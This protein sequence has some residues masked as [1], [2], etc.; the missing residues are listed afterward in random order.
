[1][2]KFYQTLKQLSLLLLLLFVSGIAFGQTTY[3]DDNFDDGDILGWTEGSTGDWVSSTDTPINGT[4]S[5]KHNLSG[6]SGTSYISTTISSADLTVEDFTWRFQLQNG[7]WDPSSSNKFWVYIVANESDLTSSTVDGYAVGVNLTGSSDLLTL[8]KVTDGAADVALITSTFDW[9]SSNVVGIEVT[10]SSLGGWELSFDSDGGFDALS[11]AGTASNSDYTTFTDFGLEFTFSSTRAGLLWMDDVNV[12]GTAAATNTIVQFSSASASIGE[13]DGTYNITLSIA[14][15]DA[16][17]ATTV[18]VA[19][20]SGDAA[21]I[22]SYTTQ[23][24]TFAAGSSADETV[25]LTITDDATYEGDETLTFTLQNVSGGNSAALGAQTTFDL[26]IMDNDPLPEATLPYSETFDTDLSGVYTYSVSGATKEWYYSSGV[27]VANGYNS[28]DVEEDWLILPSI[29]LDNYTSE[30]INFDTEYSFG[31]DDANNYLKLMYSTDY[32][33]TGDPTSA[34]WTELSYTQPA[35]SGTQTNS[36]NVDL[37]SI[38]GTSVYLAFKYRYES[39]SYRSWEVDNIIVEETPASILTVTA[40]LTDFGNVDVNTTSA[41]QTFTVEG[42]ALTGDITVTTPTNFEVSLTS[43]SGFGSSVS[44]TPSSGTVATTSIFVRF[45]PTSTLN[46]LKSGE[47]TVSTPGLTDETIAVT[48]TE[49]GN[50]GIANDLIISEYFEG[51]GN[52]KYIE[53]YNASGSQVDLSAYTVKQ[54]NNGSGFDGASPPETYSIDLTGTLDAGDVYIIYNGAADNATILAEGDLALSYGNNPGDRVASFNGD[55]AIGLFKNGVLIDLF[56]DPNN[57]PGSSWSAAGVSGATV[58]H[59]MVRKSAIITGNVDIL[60]S[61]GTDATNSEWIVLA[62]DD[63]SDIGNHFACAPP[64]SQA[65]AVTFGT[66]DETSMVINWTQGNGTDALVVVKEGSVVDTNPESGTAYTADAAFGTGAELGMGNFVVFAG[67]S[68]TQTVTVTGLTQ[69]TT[70]HVAVYE[71]NSSDNC[72]NVDTP[73][74][75]SNDTTTPNDADSD[76]TANGGTTSDID[77][78]TYQTASTLTDAN[79]V[80]LF[81]FDINDKGT[82]DAQ[83]TT[84]TDISFS[85]SNF[86]NVRTIALFDGATNVAEMSS[87]ATVDFTGL[88]I[89][90]ASGMSKSIAVRATFMESVDDEE[91]IQLAITSATADAGGSVFAAADAGGAESSI[92]TADLNAIAVTATAFEI[93]APTSVQINVDFGITADAVDANGN[94][95]IAA[96]D[97]TLSLNTGTG[98]VSSTTGLG[99]NAMINGSYTWSDVQYDMEETIT[100]NITDGSITST[101]GSIEASTVA[102]NLEDF[103]NFPET[104]TSYV[105]G[106]FTGNDGSTWSYVQTSGNSS[107]AVSAPTPV[108]GRNR[109]PAA[110]VTSGTISGGIGTLNFDY[111]QAFSTNVNLEVYVNDVLVT[112]VTSSSETGVIKNSGDIAVDVAGDIVIS[113]RQPTDAGQVGIDNIEWTSFNSTAPAI[114]IDV[115][116]FVADFGPTTVG[117]S[118][119]SSSFIVSGENLTA[120]ITVTAPTGFEVS[121][122]D[123]NFSTSVNLTQSAG[124]VAATAVYTRFNPSS[125][126]YFSDDISITSTGANDKTLTVTGTGLNADAIYFEGFDTCPS[127]TMVVFSAA[128]DKDWG[129]T[130]SGYNGNAAKM[131]GFGSDVANDEWLITPSIDLSSATHATLT[132]YSWTKY[133]DAIYPPI[134]AMVSTDYSGA[135]DPTSATWTALD[136]LWSSENSEIWTSSGDLDL[137]SYVGGSVYVAFHFTSTGT[138]GG[139]VADW[140]IDDILI[141]DRSSVPNPSV[142]VT[143]ALT[144]FGSIDNG[145][146]SASQSFTVEGTNLT[147]DISIEASSNFEVSLDDVAFASSVSLTPTSGTVVSTTI[148]VRFAPDSGINGA[149]NGEITV[150]TESANNQTIAVSGTETGNAVIEGDLFFSQYI[151][152]SG[153]NKAIEIYNGTGAAVDL[154]N[155]VVKQS[156]GGVGFDND[157]VADVYTLPLS[158]TLAA[159]DVYVIYNADATD[160][161]IIAEGDLALTYAD[162][163]DGVRVAAFTGDDAMGLFKDGILIDLIGDANNDPGTAWEVAG[164]AD[165]TTNHT[166]VRKETIATGN[167]TPLGSFGTS[168]SDSE[169]IVLDQDDM[170]GLGSHNVAVVE[171]GFT[172]DDTNFDGAFGTVNVGETS[173]ASSYVVSGSD[174]TGDLTITIPAGFEASLTS[175]FS[176]QVGNSTLPLS[177]TP[178]GG[179]IDKVTVFVRFAP[180]AEG[181]FSGNLVHTAT[182]FDPVNLA[183]TGEGEAA[184]GLGD[185]LKYGIAVYPNPASN[186]LY[187]EIPGSFGKAEASLLSLNGEFIKINVLNDSKQVD[188]TGLRS[189]I[190]ML[191]ITNNEA[192]VYQRISVK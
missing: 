57:D 94:T 180:D 183:V 98:I 159:G 97:V 74:T 167:I 117:T 11:S 127:S 55:D 181:S 37:T 170:T 4:N 102:T 142:T 66:T 178:T 107:G 118:T 69:G 18:E 147:A 87:A 163:G 53:I 105:D 186:V 123:T 184:L 130:T 164:I 175:D 67:T 58:N 145:S 64:S 72:Y 146:V 106:T 15:A 138:G 65:T 187:V 166:L 144:D 70:Y 22:N 109:T 93:T 152:G 71:Y 12:E 50:V 78:A 60:G 190:Y 91:Q 31:T 113:F 10:R 148:F 134:S 191:R 104:G 177:I 33:G 6:V 24:A 7:A 174:L 185:A 150:S 48:G 40:S 21:D 128:S 30:F 3:L 81:M 13:G 131:A 172:V 140:A 110:E 156:H 182:G 85:I 126:E 41:E 157:P 61:F 2:I 96:R 169:W 158:G 137:N 39:G 51:S 76:I 79:S 135:G 162:T 62:Q 17:N 35:S 20:T 19:L 56:G 32:A 75:G 114:N 77:Y 63:V 116:S 49:T 90:A 133:T 95:D 136:P 188:L 73:A 153:N 125:A 192:V 124:A 88:S 160:A 103:T 29:N 47:I 80:S 23:T 44:V 165:A 168:E 1:M 122:D 121:I 84:L 38:S 27:A 36:G 46:S 115:T 92:A 54:A 173:D 171:P 86:E 68:S 176:N 83:P 100:L 179:T 59:T 34:T 99:P 52:N 155:Y 101:S 120:D 154:S 161:T 9:N 26:T 149:T 112:T 45:A 8:W 82:T 111:I 89:E 5:L 132:F 143:S 119:A 151:E 42:T 28:G 16:T 189:G 14:N 129:C 108:L 141:E 25:T 139:E 43:G